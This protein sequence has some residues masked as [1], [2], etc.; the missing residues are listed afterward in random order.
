[1][2]KSSQLPRGFQGALFAPDIVPLV[3]GGNDRSPVTLA[4][5]NALNAYDGTRRLPDDA[6]RVSS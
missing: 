3:D 5:T 6:V 1:V 4:G 2:A